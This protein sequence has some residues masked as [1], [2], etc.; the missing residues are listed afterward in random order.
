MKKGFFLI[1]SAALLL[2]CA[3]QPVPTP[4]DKAIAKGV[5]HTALSRPEGPWEIRVIRIARSAKVSIEMVMSHDTLSGRE[6]VAD[7]ASR[8]EKQNKHVIAGVNG[9][10]YFIGG[11]QEKEGLPL[12]P[13]VSFGRLFTSGH[14]HGAFYIDGTG[15][16]HI[17]SQIGRA[18]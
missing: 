14:S 10:F 3:S 15:V 7:V 12:G 9:D 13:S 1:F 16:P 6:R 17:D 18:S 4:E 8:L 11:D 2:L 5:S